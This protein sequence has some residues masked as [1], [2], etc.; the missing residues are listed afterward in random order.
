[1]KHTLTLNLYLWVHNLVLMCALFMLYY[2]GKFNNGKCK[3][4]FPYHEKFSPPLLVFDP[5]SSF[6]DLSFPEMRPFLLK[7][8]ILSF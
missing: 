4:M 7:I 8:S 6:F 1:M 2:L 3:S 5:Q